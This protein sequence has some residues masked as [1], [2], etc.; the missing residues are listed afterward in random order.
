MNV[1]KLQT[2]GD[3]WNIMSHT[4]RSLGGMVEKNIVTTNPARKGTNTQHAM[5]N[6]RAPQEDGPRACTETT[7]MIILCGYLR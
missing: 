7:I 5:Q 2:L 3:G 6:H 1:R 4:R